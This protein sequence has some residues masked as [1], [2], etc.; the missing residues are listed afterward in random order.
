MQLIKN[1]DT[2]PYIRILAFN[3][4]GREVLKEIKNKSEIKIINK[5]SNISFS[6]D[7]TIFKTLI[8]YDIKSTNIYNSVYYKNNK[9]LVKA[10]WIFILIQYM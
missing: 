10:L 9:D 7:D 1:I 8:S 3:D 5:F 4:K 2:I 6:L